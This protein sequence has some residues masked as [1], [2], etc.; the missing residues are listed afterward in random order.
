MMVNGKLA[1]CCI[2]QAKAGYTPCG[3]AQESHV[4][5]SEYKQTHIKVYQILMQV[6]AS[7]QRP[8]AWHAVANM[9]TDERQARA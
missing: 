3:R 9:R 2:A 4:C 7:P 6:F 5:I 1:L 8:S